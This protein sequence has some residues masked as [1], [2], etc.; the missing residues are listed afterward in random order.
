VNV[1]K[2]AREPRWIRRLS[3]PIVRKVVTG[4]IG[5]LLLAAG[6]AI[7]PLPGPFSIPLILAGVTVLSWEYPWAKRARQWTLDKFRN[8]RERR[9]AKARR[10]AEDR[11]A[12]SGRH[13]PDRRVA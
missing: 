13:G 11:N 3:S 2:V 10:R 4:I 8:F 5:A 1:E 7:T 6:V 9:R 12:A